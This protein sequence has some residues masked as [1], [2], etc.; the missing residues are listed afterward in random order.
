[1]DCSTPSFPALHCLPE[2]VQTHV[3]PT[4]SFSDVSFSSCPQS[5]PEWGSFPMSCLFISGG[6]SI[7][8]SA[9]VLPLNIQ[10]WFPSG[11]MGLISLMFKGL[12][13]AFSSTTFQKHQFVSAQPSLWSN[14]HIHTW[15]LEK[16]QLWLY[17]PL[18][19]K[20]C[21]YLN[22]LSSFVI[23]FL[24]RSR[25]LLILWLQSLSAVILESKK[26]KSVTISIVYPSI[27][28]EM[29]GLDAMIL[30]FWMLSFKPTFSLSS[31]TFIKRPFSSFSLSAIN[32]VSSAYLRLLIFLLAI[33]IPACAS[34]SPEFHMIYSSQKLNNQGDNI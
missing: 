17:G 12:S 26:I 5:F 21:L 20:W 29:M 13:R 15:L 32:V 30:V 3:H 1:M 34:S 28:H 7:G 23:A 14:S 27:C 4:T 33:V 9:S 10:G 22:T 19:A 25:C 31:F 24:P 8:V 11:L 18:S 6:Q 16:L 2:F